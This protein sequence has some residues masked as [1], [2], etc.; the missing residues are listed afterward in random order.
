MTGHEHEPPRKGYLVANLPHCTPEIDIRVPSINDAHEEE[1]G[2]Q[3]NAVDE[4]EGRT[5]A[6]G[7]VKEPVD[8]EERCAQLP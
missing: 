6:A 4:L 3:E 7:L 1:C 8:I 5:G 2:Q